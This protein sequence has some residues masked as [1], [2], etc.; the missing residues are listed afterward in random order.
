MLFA[1]SLPKTLCLL[2]YSNFY[3]Y[4]VRGDLSKASGC[5]QDFDVVFLGDESGGYVAAVIVSVLLGCHTQ[6]N[7]LVEVM[8]SVKEPCLYLA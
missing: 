5:M 6:G 2:N 7:T 8:E 4:P 3:V 1:C